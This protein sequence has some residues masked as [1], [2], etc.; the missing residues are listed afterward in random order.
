[1]DSKD[2]IELIKIKKD[3]KD[4]K[5]TFTKSYDYKNKSI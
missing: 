3:V 5:N 1:M 2:L 4:S